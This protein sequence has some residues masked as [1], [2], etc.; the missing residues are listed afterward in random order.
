MA[1]ISL[2]AEEEKLFEGQPHGFPFGDF[3]VADVMLPEG[4]D[5][6][7]ASDS[8]EEEEDLNAESGFGNVLG[9]CLQRAATVRA[10]H[11]G[12]AS[13]AMVPL[14]PPP[15]PPL[16]LRVGRRRG[17]AVPTAVATSH[18]CLPSCPRRARHSRGQPAPGGPRKVRQAHRHP[19][20][21]LQRHWAHP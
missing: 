12:A 19:G 3:D 6:G 16:P 18:S 11:W 10:C 1:A 14:P 4:D 8:E 21:D 2:T 5:M 9:A 15:L 17:A 20:Q 7:I 13:R